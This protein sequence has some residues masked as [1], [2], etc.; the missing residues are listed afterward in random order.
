MYFIFSFIFGLLFGRKIQKRSILALFFWAI[1]LLVTGIII[2]F[3]LEKPW[4][5]A[6]SIVG[7]LSITI[8]MLATVLRF[9]LFSSFSISY[10]NWRME[11][12]NKILKKKGFE[13]QKMEINHAFIKKKQKEMSWLSIFI[14]FFIGCLLLI[15]SLPFLFS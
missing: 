13:P 1:F 6:T 12:Q 11:S 9:G 3:V 2:I 14:G 7:L 4:F 10:H 15:I 8:S 5:D